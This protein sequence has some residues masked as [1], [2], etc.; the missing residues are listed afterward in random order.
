MY[1]ATNKTNKKTFKMIDQSNF[2]SLI[3][4]ISENLSFV[5]QFDEFLWAKSSHST[6]LNVSITQTNLKAIIMPT[7]T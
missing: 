5:N 1:I 4:L 7:K 6:M 2:V 3:R